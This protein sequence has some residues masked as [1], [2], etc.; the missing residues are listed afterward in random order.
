MSLLDSVSWVI[1]DFAILRGEEGFSL[2]ILLTIEFLFVIFLV[3]DVNVF[4]TL[5]ANN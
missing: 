1:A 4:A 2:T 3:L 5:A